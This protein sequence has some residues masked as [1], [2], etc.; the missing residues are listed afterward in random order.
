[1]S[2][3]KLDIFA[4]LLEIAKNGA[5]RDRI[6]SQIDVH[7]KIVDSSL[8]LLTDLDLLKEAHNSPVSL[9]TTERGLQFLTEYQGLTR[10][11]GSAEEAPQKR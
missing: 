11:L 4:Q 10:K 2:R 1:M 9:V 6:T 5:T 7:E 8:S 3:S